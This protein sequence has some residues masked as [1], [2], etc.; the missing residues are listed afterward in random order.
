MCDRIQTAVEVIKTQK[1]KTLTKE[2]SLVL[3][4]KV[5]EDNNKIGDR[6]KNL[7]KAVDE[8]KNDVSYVKGDVKLIKEMMEHRRRT[9]WDK[10]PLLKDLPTLFWITVI[11]FVGCLFSQLGA[12]MSWVNNVFTFGGQ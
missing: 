4:E 6:M 12:N 5:I 9:F 7:E 2:E 11:F 3:F 10:I 1:R 8:L